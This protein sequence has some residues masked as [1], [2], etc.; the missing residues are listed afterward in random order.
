MMLASG[1]VLCINTGGTISSFDSPEG[2]APVGG[3]RFHALLRSNPQ[4]CDLS[5]PQE[6]SLLNSSDFVQGRVLESITTPIHLAD[7]RPLVV[8][9]LELVRFIESPEITVQ[10]YNQL[11]D[12]IK[13]N[14]DCYNGFIIL[15]G[16]DTLAYTAS[17]LGYVFH[18][19][20]KPIVLTGS[21]ESQI[22]ISCARSDGW[23]NF[24]ESCVAAGTLD[25]SG[26]GVVFQHRLLNGTRA[27]KVSPNLLAAMESPNF[28]PVAEFNVNITMAKSAARSHRR[29]VS[30]VSIVGIS[31]KTRI[32]VCHIY[33]GI[34]GSALRAQI[35]NDNC[36]EAVI[37]AAF[38][39]GN[40]PIS[41]ESGFLT[42][43]KWAIKR[44]VFVVV[45]SQC[46]Y[47]DVIPIYPLGRMLLSIGVVPGY[48]LTLEAAF[49]KILWLFSQD[50]TTEERSRLFQTPIAN[51]LTAI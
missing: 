49:G 22:P 16:T 31:T 46:R 13:N 12:L 3:S 18:K 5:A 29:P 33:P 37:L 24:V 9:M 35:E 23:G 38:G 21:Q 6:A 25:W 48:D 15:H 34:S 26:V 47:P 14:W 50:L 17:V 51:D 45:V 36:C 8:D 2:L 19:V 43:V 4:I 39:S 44:G 11:I 20:G 1:R 42:A 41:P 7:G 30:P 32:R 40:V 28:P 10:D 27:T